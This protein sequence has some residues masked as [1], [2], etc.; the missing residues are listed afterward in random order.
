MSRSGQSLVE[1]AIIVP[2]F[3]LLLLGMLELGLAFTHHQ[4]L[5]YATRE[6]ARTGSA[7][8]NGGGK[9]GCGSGGS[10]SAATVDQQIVAAVERV[11]TSEGSPV[12]DNLSRIPT[13]RI[14]LA[15]PTGGESGA[16]VDVWNYKAG[17]GPVVDGKAL[18]YVAGTTNYPAC[19]RTFQPPAQA[20]GVSLKYTYQLQTGLGG[21]LGFF[22]GKGWTSIAMSDSTVMNINPTNLNFVP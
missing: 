1:F 4:T 3:M 19:S 20:L 17:A 21:I 10:P 14:F 6:G 2:L 15:T 12:K 8:A 22:G 9:L 13:I 16:S 5:E 11:L 18:D 7:L